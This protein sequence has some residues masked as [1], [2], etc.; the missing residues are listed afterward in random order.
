MGGT[1]VNWGQ[2]HVWREISRYDMRKELE[3]SQDYSHGV[4]HF[5]LFTENGEKNNLSHDDEVSFTMIVV[6]I[7]VL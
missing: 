2:A 1:W 3:I 7:T 5:S 6:L 4:D